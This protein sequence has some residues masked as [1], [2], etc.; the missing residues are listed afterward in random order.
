MLRDLT[1]G[2][3][4]E[5]LDLVN[6]E[7][8]EGDGRP[9]VMVNFVTS[10]DGATTVGGR[11]SALGDDDDLAMFKAIRSLPDVI[12]VGAGTVRAE[13]Y[14]PVI[15]D[16]RRRAVRRERGQAEDPILAIVSGSLGVDPEAR[17][18]G[19]PDHKP[20]ILTSTTANPG[21]LVNIGDMA[22]V[23]FLIEL[24]PATILDQLGAANV[25]LVEGGPTLTGQFVAAGLVDEMCLTISPVLVGGDSKRVAVGAEANPP[26][27]MRLARA[28]RGER[29]LF[30][31]YL[32]A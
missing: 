17:I 25:V 23:A 26:L 30:L 11:S 1:T 18:F 20:L 15:L 28:H 4:V 24:T 14:R 31:R 6:A 19:D 22:E 8:R 3:E 5:A 29:S 10:I 9:W 13:D 16:E 32:R 21:R 27:G 7:S 12:L 2:D